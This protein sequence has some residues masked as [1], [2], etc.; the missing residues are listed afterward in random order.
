MAMREAPYAINKMLRDYDSDLE[1]EWCPQSHAWYFMYCGTKQQSCLLHPDGNVILDLYPSEVM[2]IVERTDQNKYFG[3][4][5]QR[6]KR[7]QIMREGEY[8]RKCA[9]DARMAEM[10]QEATEQIDCKLRGHAKPFVHITN[11][12]LNEEKENAKVSTI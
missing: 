11:N 6:L 3:T 4:F 2:E 8:R 5:L 9:F 7:A 1:I 12:T 10:R